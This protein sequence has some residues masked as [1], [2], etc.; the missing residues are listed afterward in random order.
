[1]KNMRELINLMEGVSA[2][3]GLGESHVDEKA[4]P[5][6]EDTVM[7]LKKQY[8]GEPE[9]AFATAWSIYNKKTGKTEEGLGME[10][11]GDDP[12]GAEQDPG[13]MAMGD[14]G[15]Q[16]EGEFNSEQVDQALDM[17]SNL[18][19]SFVEPEQALEM[20]KQHFTEAG[21]GEDELACIEDAIMDHYGVDVVGDEPND[22]MD[23]DFD[24][25]M[26]SAGHGSDED[27]GD[28]GG[29]DEFEEAVD[30]NNGYGEINNANGDDFFPDGA[31][32]P[33]TKTVGPSGA[34]QGDN[35]E[36]KK[37]EVNEVHKELVYG[38]RNYLKES[39]AQKKKLTEAGYQLV[40]VIHITA[41]RNGDPQEDD[42]FT[43]T[44]GQGNYPLAEDGDVFFAGDKN[45]PNIQQLDGPPHSVNK[46]LFLF[47]V[48]GKL[49]LYDGNFRLKKSFNSMGDFLYDYRQDPSFAHP[50]KINF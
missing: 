50:Y 11:A 1:M 20:V 31:D 5:G 10:E 26:A 35:P 29:H 36:Q 13:A 45:N 14:V 18:R 7:D 46:E 27:Y 28:F 38:Y 42:L 3:P 44:D 22:S 25:A 16:P 6:M 4:P 41:D 39:E 40:H 12:M 15:A 34:R 8:P 19:N 37:M 49:G 47:S 23:G 43:C 48:N 30:L 32:S 24:S 21:A 33:V 9:K 2:I 17:F